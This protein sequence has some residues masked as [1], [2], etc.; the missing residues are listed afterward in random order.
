MITVVLMVLEVK[1][2]KNFG[3]ATKI[4]PIF[5]LIGATVTAAACSCYMGS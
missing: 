4:T 1:F 2:D 5:D 3:D